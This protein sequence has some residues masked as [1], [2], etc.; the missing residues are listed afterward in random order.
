MPLL[1]FFFSSCS[2][3]N[4]RWVLQSSQSS[5]P[6]CRR[7]SRIYMPPEDQYFGLEIELVLS[8]KDHDHNLFINV[9]SRKIPPHKNQD[10]RAV[11]TIEIE[12][13]T[14]TCL[15][16][17]LEGGQRLRVPEDCAQQIITAFLTN[18]TILIKLQGYQR[19]IKPLNFPSLFTNFANK[20]EKTIK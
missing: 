18:K 7:F 2:A 6:S 3:T 1:L 8:P 15:A 14:N 10:K 5:L 13:K 17:R 19:S 11:V 16:D 4:E 12:G 9:F 20:T